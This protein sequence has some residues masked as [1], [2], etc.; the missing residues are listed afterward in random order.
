MNSKKKTRK[1]E[2]S[3]KETWWGLLSPIIDVGDNLMYTFVCDVKS[4]WRIFNGF[5]RGEISK[6]NSVCITLIQKK[7]ESLKKSICKCRTIVPNKSTVFPKNRL[8]TK[9]NR[10][11]PKISIYSKKI[12]S[13]QIK[14]VI[15]TP[16]HSPHKSIII[17]V[18]S[19]KCW[20]GIQLTDDLS[21]TSF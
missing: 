14:L 8:F 18:I 10:F 7:S 13:F 4:E 15:I 11:T 5:W 1:N 17:Y 19:N 20:F 12:D 21:L 3:I 6:W 16:F 2:H 9:N